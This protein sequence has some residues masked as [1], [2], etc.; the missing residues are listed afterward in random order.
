MLNINVIYISR[1]VHKNVYR[2][3]VRQPHNNKSRVWED[4]KCREFTHW[5]GKT[6]SSALW[7]GGDSFHSASHYIPPTMNITTVPSRSRTQSSYPNSMMNNDS[8]GKVSSTTPTPT[9][10][11]TKSTSPVDRYIDDNTCNVKSKTEYYDTD[12]ILSK[13]GFTDNTCHNCLKRNSD[14]HGL[15]MQCAKCK[16]AYYCGMK[17]RGLAL[18][19]CWWWL[20]VGFYGI[21]FAWICLCHV[22]VILLP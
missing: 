1:F 14:L 5:K 8:C 3:T 15:L 4:R 10:T 22:V 6:N 21:Y 12:R 11:K 9:P 16:K 2:S 7:L 17:V 20:L 13:W 18:C 19:C